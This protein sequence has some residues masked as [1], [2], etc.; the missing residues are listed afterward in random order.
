MDKKIPLEPLSS[1]NIK[2]AFRKRR[3][4]YWAAMP[5]LFVAM[6]FLIAGEHV[7]DSG[8]VFG[9]PAVIAKWIPYIAFIG[10]G[11]L[12]VAVWRCPVCRG[13]LGKTLNPRTCR[14]C[15]VELR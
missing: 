4:M 13:L 5:L 11:A 8:T 2:A 1:V 15:G 6:A 10:Y 14:K 7:P 3:S 9:I 12:C